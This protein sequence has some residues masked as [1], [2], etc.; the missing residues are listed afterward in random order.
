MACYQ[1]KRNTNPNFGDY[2]VIPILFPIMSY[3]E[4]FIRM[5][6]EVDDV[7]LSSSYYSQLGNIDPV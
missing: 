2:Q 1:L 7:L 3:F 4:S 6:I 5:N